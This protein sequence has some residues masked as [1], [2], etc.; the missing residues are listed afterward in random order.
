MLSIRF[1]NGNV[2]IE[3][4]DKPI[5]VRFAE[6]KKTKPETATTATPATATTHAQPKPVAT[7]TPTP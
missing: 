5:E 3:G 1:L 6:T 2:Y 7:H 4:S